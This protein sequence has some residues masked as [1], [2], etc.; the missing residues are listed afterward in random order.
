M[1]IV[2]DEPETAP[3]MTEKPTY[4]PQKKYR[5]EPTDQFVINGV[6]MSALINATRSIL[7]TPEARLIMDAMRAN[8]V[9]ERALAKL[10]ESGIVKEI[11]PEK[12][13]K[14]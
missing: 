1:E 9:A 14:L 8:D 7:N 13:G 4:D 11:Q 5:W 12:T 10:V 6:E 2:R 3:K